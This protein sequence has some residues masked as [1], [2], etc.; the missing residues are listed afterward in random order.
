[1]TGPRRPICRASASSLIVAFALIIAMGCGREG[2][3]QY[4]TSEPVATSEVPS[5][6]T[7]LT[8]TARAG[9]ELFNASCSICHGASAS[10]TSRG[11]T[12]IDRL[13]HPGHHSDLS[14]RSAVSQG[15]RQHHWTFGSMPPIPGVSPGDVEKIIC[16]IR[17]LQRAD[18]IFEGDAFPTAC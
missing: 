6:G 11:P 15:V 4:E 1:M 5:A 13:Y 17:E 16:Y 14:I 9:E 8:E 12:L 7:P 10:G 2:A 18:G 3:P